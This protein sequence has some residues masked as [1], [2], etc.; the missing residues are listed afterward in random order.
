MKKTSIF[1]ASTVMFLSLNANANKMGKTEACPQLDKIVEIG[2][3]VYRASGNDGEWLGIIQNVL[4]DNN[5]I[6]SFNSA[7]ILQENDTSPMKFQHCAYNL[8]RSSQLQMRFIHNKIPSY[9]VNTIGNEWK[10]DSGPFGL[11]ETICTSP[12]PEKCEF[13]ILK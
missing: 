5:K 2:T 13:S 3:G 10:K 11:I 4:P 8:Q 7:S 1:I 6:E 12:Q 9:T